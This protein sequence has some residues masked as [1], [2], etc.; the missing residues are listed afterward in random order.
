MPLASDRS[1]GDVLMDKR[2]SLPFYAG[3]IYRLVS[4]VFG[5]ALI[6][7]GFC[8]LFLAETHPALRI[9]GGIGVILLG[10]NMAWSAHTA[11]ESW[12]SRIGP[13]P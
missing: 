1:R 13:L 2:E 10:C 3:T 7:G 11:K 9:P 12:L 6:I 4:A 5:L 8:A